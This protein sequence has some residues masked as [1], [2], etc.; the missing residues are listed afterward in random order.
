[1]FQAQPVPVPRWERAGAGTPSRWW[2]CRAQGVVFA[3]DSGPSRGIDD[4]WR[5]INARHHKSG[6]LEHPLFL[7]RC[8]GA[9][10]RRNYGRS[11]D[12]AGR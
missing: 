4:R 11:V 9:R 7:N 6:K 1:M 2:F 8:H 3:A 10:F 5:K 12:R